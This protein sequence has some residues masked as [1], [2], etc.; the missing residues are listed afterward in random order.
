MKELLP[1]VSNAIM[2]LLRPGVLT[3][4]SS[5]IKSRNVSS[6]NFMLESHQRPGRTSRLPDGT[7]SSVVNLVLK[8]GTH[9]YMC[10]SGLN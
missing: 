2:C 8:L 1:H 5:R 9:A 7:L 6:V 4:K 10:K 3:N